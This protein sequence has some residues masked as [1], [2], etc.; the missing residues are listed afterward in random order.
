MWS[1]NGFLTETEMAVS[2]RERA[3]SREASEP[4]GGVPGAQLA[5][6]GG[7][8][9]LGHPQSLPCRTD[10]RARKPVTSS[11]G[12]VMWEGG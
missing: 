1:H 10:T 4:V 3:G 6:V 8:C 11:I 7:A 2:Q 5:G 9:Y 12:K